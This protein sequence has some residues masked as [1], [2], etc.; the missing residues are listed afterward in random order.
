MLQNARVAV[1]GTAEGELLL[2]NHALEGTE[3]FAFWKLKLIEI[4]QCLAGAHLLEV[5]AAIV[6][7]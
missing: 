4:D 1:V 2:G 6:G 5:L 7:R 3:V